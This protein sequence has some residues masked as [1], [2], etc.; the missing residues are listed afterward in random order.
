M[1]SDGNRKRRFRWSTEYDE[2]AVDAM[3]IIRVRARNAERTVDLEPLR[4]IFPG[5]DR[6]GVRNRVRRIIR[7]I[8]GYVRRLE[9][10]WGKLWLEFRGT[11]GLSDEHPHS[12]RNFDLAEHI[13]FLRQRIDKKS[14]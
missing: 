11:D 7:P 3:A 4:Q 2:L 14:L 5:I 8:E 6:N 9:T 13:I 12:L 1:G 10:A